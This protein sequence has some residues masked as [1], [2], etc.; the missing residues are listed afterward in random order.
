MGQLG[1]AYHVTTYTLIFEETHYNNYLKTH[2]NN[3]LIEVNVPVAVPPVVLHIASVGTCGMPMY[4]CHSYCS[5]VQS[6]FHTR[7]FPY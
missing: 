5:G 2:Y 4:S 6:Y 7:Y 3:Y 1:H